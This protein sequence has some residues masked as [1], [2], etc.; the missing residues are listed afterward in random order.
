MTL[1]DNVSQAYGNSRLLNWRKRDGRTIRF[2]VQPLAWNWRT[3]FL[4]PSKDP[5]GNGSGVFFYTQDKQTYMIGE[6]GA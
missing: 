2:T 5:E 1:S 4:Y 3:V 6:V